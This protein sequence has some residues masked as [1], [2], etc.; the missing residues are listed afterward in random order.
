MVVAWRFG[1]VSLEIRWISNPQP[2]GQRNGRKVDRL[3]SV[4]SAVR[5]LNFKPPGCSHISPSNTALSSM[6][7]VKA[8][9]QTQ[10]TCKCGLECPLQCD[11]VFSFDAK[12]R[13][14]ATEVHEPSEPA[15][16]DLDN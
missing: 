6:E 12:P 11:S 10:G 3:R 9:L 8:Y 13:E 16:R 15:V 4:L 1:D 14:R 5:V 2:L 7:Q